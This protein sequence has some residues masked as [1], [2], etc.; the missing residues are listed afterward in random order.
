MANQ[1][2]VKMIAGLLVRYEVE[3]EEGALVLG[4]REFTILKP[5]RK[6]RVVV[7]RREG[8]ETERETEGGRAAA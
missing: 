8:R 1:F 6:Y 2:V 5:D 7:R 3:L 4:T